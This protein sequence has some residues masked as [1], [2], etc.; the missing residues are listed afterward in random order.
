VEPIP[1]D[2]KKFLDENIDSFDQ[3][4]ILRVLGEERDKQ[5]DVVS[6]AKEIHLAPH[7]LAPHVNALDAR[8]LL[9]SAI[10]GN[11]SV[12]RHGARTPEL[13]HQLDRLLE[14]YAERPVTMIRMVSTRARDVL[15]TFAEAFRLRKD[16]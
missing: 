15:Q 3:L 11:T 9:T 7:V 12:I 13:A 6:F 8:G 14:L 16:E 5:W 4:E 1:E 10:A 2:I